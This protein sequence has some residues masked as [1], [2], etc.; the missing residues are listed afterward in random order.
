MLTKLQSKKYSKEVIGKIK[1]NYKRKCA[2]V[3][4]YENLI[5]LFKEVKNT[6]LYFYGI[7]LSRKKEEQK[8]DLN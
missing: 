6:K 3:K 8:E 2:E 1:E 5:N 7:E 4:F